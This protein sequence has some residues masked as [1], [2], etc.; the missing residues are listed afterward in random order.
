MP[1]EIY[2]SNVKNTRRPLFLTILCVLTFIGSIAGIII[3]SKG[4]INAEE[5]VEKIASGK[6]KTQLR[7]LFSSNSGN[8]ER[9]TISNL[10]VENYQKYSI[11]CVASY[12]LCLVGTVLMFRLK[13][14]GFY[15][16]TLGTFFN[17]ITHF[18]LFGDNFASMG[19]SILAALSG[20][21]FVILF[22]LNLKWMDEG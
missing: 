13:R 1:E 20:F 6:A 17:L 7:N 14:T 9:V 12:I 3:N 16:F 22:G 8:T 15:S 5:E 4:F 11:G 19:L 2:N 10:N 18:L 21:V